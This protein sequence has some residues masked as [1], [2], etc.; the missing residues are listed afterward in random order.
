MNRARA[1]PDRAGGID[2][3]PAARDATAKRSNPKWKGRRRIPLSAWPAEEK[4]PL[5]AGRRPPP[6][7]PARLIPAA[8]GRH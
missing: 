1:L 2:P 3:A 8:S 5:T 4:S 6:C 7:V